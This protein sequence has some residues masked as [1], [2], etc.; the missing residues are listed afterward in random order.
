[1]LGIQGVLVN[2]EQLDGDT[3]KIKVPTQHKNS[4]IILL[5]HYPKTI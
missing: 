4:E 5:P 2:P 3:I 1:M